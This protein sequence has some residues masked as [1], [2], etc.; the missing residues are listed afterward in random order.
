MAEIGHYQLSVGIQKV[1][2]VNIPEMA[3]LAAIIEQA[4]KDSFRPF[5]SFTSSDSLEKQTKRI[6]KTISKKGGEAKKYYQKKKHRALT[7]DDALLARRRL[8]KPDKDFDYF[9]EIL[10]MRAHL[11]RKS[12]LNILK[13]VERCEQEIWSHCIDVDKAYYERY[14]PVEEPQLFF[15]YSI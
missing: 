9:F 2:K 10:E 8:S 13:E 15:R 5:F 1:M 6:K 3:L 14:K 7:V 11:F 4:M 12:F